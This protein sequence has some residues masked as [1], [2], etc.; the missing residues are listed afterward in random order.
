MP[1]DK[2]YTDCDRK[3]EQVDSLLSYYITLSL[4]FFNEINTSK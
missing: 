1:Q 4:S 2:I 3:S